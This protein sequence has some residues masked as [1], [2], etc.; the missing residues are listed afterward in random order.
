MH[1]GI[2]KTCNLLR[3]DGLELNLQ[4]L[5]Y[6]HTVKVQANEVTPCI[7]IS[8]KLAMQIT[9][10][11]GKTNK[12]GKHVFQAFPEQARRLELFNTSQME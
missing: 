4:Y 2:K 11:Q 8:F 6:A 7:A 12:H 9:E 1:W 3:C 5:R 10:T